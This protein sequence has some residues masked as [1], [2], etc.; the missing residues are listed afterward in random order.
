MIGYNWTMRVKN[1]PSNLS[2]YSRRALN[3]R[4]NSSPFL[5]GDLFSDNADFSF[6][7]PRFRQ[8]KLS[9]RDIS[10]SRVIFCPSH[11][12]EEMLELYGCY[13]SASVLIL[14]NSDRDFH[15]LDLKLPPSIKHIF[16]QNLLNPSLRA[17]VLPIG[18][19]N[20]RLATNGQLR[21]FSSSF[22][23][24]EKYKK[25]LIG[26]FSRTHSE[27]KV[28]FTEEI[29]LSEDIVYLSGRFSPKMYAQLSSKF[30]F[31]AAPRGNGIDTHRFWESLYRGSLPI[32]LDN[33]WS[34]QIHALKI[35]HLNVNSWTSLEL[36]ALLQQ[37]YSKTIEPKMIP[38]LW[39]PFWKSRIKSHL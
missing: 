10:T 33:L 24:T 21:N 22:T 39:W 14:G 19:E 31:I 9:H 4:L 34:Q 25:I 28:F 36:E 11:K 8:R 23:L 3:W 18:I 29:A 7:T 38:S 1:I 35:P 5:T 30:Q 26:P 27:R 6:F 32:V 17:T 12:L 15:N 37:S 16:A 2:L 13:I 20:R